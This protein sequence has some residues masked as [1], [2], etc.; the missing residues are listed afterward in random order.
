MD[1]FKP[2]DF[3][4]RKKPKPK[5]PRK[6]TKKSSKRKSSKRKSSKTKT[7]GLKKIKLGKPKRVVVAVAKK[8]YTDKDGYIISTT[9]VGP[10]QTKANNKLNKAV[11]TLMSPLTPIKRKRKTRTPS[12]ARR[13]KYKPRI[14]KSKRTPPSAPKKTKKRKYKFI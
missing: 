6:S 12:I 7:K 14:R 13:G 10:N 1:A 4:P 3:T 5:S 9:V 8:S 2:F 11:K